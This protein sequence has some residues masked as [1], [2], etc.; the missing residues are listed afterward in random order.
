MNINNHL[1]NLNDITLECVSI[2]E[3]K[4]EVK[5]YCE[6]NDLDESGFSISFELEAYVVDID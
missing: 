6:C 4:R 3:A 1:D 2:E 5:R